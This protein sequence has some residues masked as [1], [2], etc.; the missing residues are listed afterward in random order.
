[1]S[2]YLG[3]ATHFAPYLYGLDVI[4]EIAER[5]PDRDY[6][7][8]NEDKVRAAKLRMA[9]LHDANGQVA[10]TLE[11]PGSPHVLVVDRQGTVQYEGELEGTDLWEM[12]ARLGR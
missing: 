5:P 4:S 6:Y 2:R 3:W 12:L 11:I 10:A 8:R 1:M 9:L 7:F